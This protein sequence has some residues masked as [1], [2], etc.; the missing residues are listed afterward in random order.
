MRTIS[1]TLL[2]AATLT[3][4]AV[5]GTVVLDADRDNT[6]YE[7]PTGALSN[8]AGDHF[9]AGVTV[10]GEIRRGVIRFDVG[11]IPQG[12]T[13]DSVTL[14][15]NMSRTLGGSSVVRLHRIQRDWGEGNSN[16]AGEEGGGA[17]SAPG[18]ATW[19]HTFF[20]GQTWNNAGGDFSA[21]TSA[22]VTVGGEGTYT[23][24]TNNMESDI[25]QWVANPSQNFGWLLR[26]DESQVGVAK[27]FDSR[28]NPNGGNRPELEIEFTPPVPVELQSFSIEG[29]SD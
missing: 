2:I 17:P 27:R 4:P 13:I 1:W 7:S 18:D 22:A 11:A 29:A 8:G 15:L 25:E 19:I 5:A 10:M 24:S 28:E 26:A 6:L 21:A 16:A 9:F 20:S 3:A 12:S 23:W 14:T